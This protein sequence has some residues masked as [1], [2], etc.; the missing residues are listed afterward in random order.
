MPGMF[1]EDN[2]SKDY[3]PHMYVG[4]YFVGKTYEFRHKKITYTCGQTKNGQI[5]IEDKN[6]E[7]VNVNKLSSK[8]LRDKAIKTAK[9]GY[10]KRQKEIKNLMKLMNGDK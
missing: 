2:T 5:F 1:G 7:A 6:S 9:G 8:V 10:Q 3:A 4:D